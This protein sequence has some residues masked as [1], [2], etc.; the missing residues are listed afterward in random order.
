[1]GAKEAKKPNHRG[2]ND[3]FRYRRRYMD[4]LVADWK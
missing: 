1:M 2:F 3:Y 4:W